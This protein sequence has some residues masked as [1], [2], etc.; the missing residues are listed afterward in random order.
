MSRTY[1]ELCDQAVVSFDLWTGSIQSTGT[2]AMT[3]AVSGTPRFGKI[4]NKQYLMTF[5]NADK[6]VSNAAIAPVVNST[7]AFWIEAWLCSGATDYFVYQVNAGGFGAYY[8]VGNRIFNLITFTAIGGAART[9]NTAVGSSPYSRN[10]YH[11][12][13]YIDPV[14]LTGQWWVDGVPYATT[15]T[16][17]NPPVLGGNAVLNVGGNAG[18]GVNTAALRV[19][20]GAPLADEVSLLYGNYQSLTVPSRL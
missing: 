18:P 14:G 2:A 1:R 6:I 13:G 17:T 9:I 12:V 15:F 5:T 7:T 8:D 19:W 20:Q 3:M 10:Q 4:G 11:A 16:N